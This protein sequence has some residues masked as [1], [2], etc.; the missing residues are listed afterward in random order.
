MGWMDRRVRAGRVAGAAMALVTVAVGA[1]A[2]EK[3]APRAASMLLRPARVFDAVSATP[4]TGW[5]VLVTGQDIAA[6]GPEAAVQ[7]PPGTRVLELPGATLLPGL[8]DAHSHIFL[9][10]YDETSWNDQVLKEPLAYRTINAVLHCER[11]LMAGFTTLRD[12][13]TEGAGYADLSVKR[14]IEEGRVPGPRLQVA[15]RAIVA[16]GSYGPGP[17]G[18]APS[19]DP[20]K[21]AEEASGTAEILRAVREQVGSRRRLGEGLRRLPPGPGPHHGADVLAGGARDA[22][23]RRRTAPGGRSRPTPLPPREC[24]GRCSRGCRPSS[25]ATAAPTRSSS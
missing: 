14:A 16:T 24:A 4:H 9:H 5:V 11:T 20:P 8:I 23:R 6:A 3:A 18:F 19:F 15:T 10:P 12:L 7:V 21:G 22:G 2:Q 17:L 25:T 1:G 13:G